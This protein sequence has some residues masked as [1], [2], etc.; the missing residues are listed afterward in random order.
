M[1][2][3][4][5][6]TK[7]PYLHPSQRNLKSDQIGPSGHKN[8][9]NV[10]VLQANWVEDRASFEQRFVDP[11]LESTTICKAS[12]QH[13]GRIRRVE[14]SPVGDMAKEL[15]FGHG[16]DFHSKSY[17][18]TNELFYADHQKM[19]DS[20]KTDSVLK[21]TSSC[22]R[23]DQTMKK[24][25]QWQE[26]LTDTK[27]FETTKAATI[28]ASGKQAAANYSFKKQSAEKWGESVRELSMDHHKT[29]LRTPFVY[30]R[31]PLL[32]T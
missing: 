28:D 20:L 1:N 26:E 10:G 7:L 21:S 16:S 12:Y 17:V 29:G 22:A 15:L 32:R 19:G 27:R 3:K 9:Y 11:P 31:S 30:H 23:S 13:P 6:P 14:P 8:E 24:Q 2:T 5:V 18:T 4:V 25:R